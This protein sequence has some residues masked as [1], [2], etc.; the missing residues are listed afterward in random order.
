[1]KRGFTLLELIVVIII[2]GVLAT[3]G[4]TQYT[5]VIEKGRTSEAKMILG[6]IRTAQEAYNLEHGT[7]AA[8]LD[9]LPVQA[10]QACQNTHYFSYSATNTTATAARC[11]GNGKTPDTTGNG[12]NITLEY[13]TGTWGGTAGY[14]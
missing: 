12:Y 4:F 14:Y 7:Y 10:P 5:K 6:S 2:L 1:M 9:A 8:N 13:T 3:L 11:T